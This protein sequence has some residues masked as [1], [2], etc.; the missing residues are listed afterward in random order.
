MINVHTSLNQG[1]VS[2]GRHLNLLRKT[3]L[4]K[5]VI[6]FG[7]SVRTDRILAVFT[8]GYPFYRK[9]KTCDRV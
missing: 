5:L 1:P 6:Y 7:L 3:Q 9:L 4:E 2:S 8:A